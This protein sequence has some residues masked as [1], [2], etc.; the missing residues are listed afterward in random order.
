MSLLLNMLSRLVVTFLPRSKHPL[1]SWLQSPSAE[2]LVN[3]RRIGERHT[4][5]NSRQTDFC[6][7]AY[8]W[9][10]PRSASNPDLHLP[11]RSSPHDLCHVWDLPWWLLA[12]VVLFT[13]WEHIPACLVA[14]VCGAGSSRGIKL[15]HPT[16]SPDTQHRCSAKSTNSDVSNWKTLQVAGAYAAVLVHHWKHSQ[17]AKLAHAHGK[18]RESIPGT[19]EGRKGPCSRVVKG[20]WGHPLW[21]L[22]LGLQPV[23]CLGTSELSWSPPGIFLRRLLSA[24][25]PWCTI[26]TP[27]RTCS[28]SEI[29]EI[30][31]L[32][33]VLLLAGVYV[34]FPM[35]F[36]L[37]YST[38]ITWLGQFQQLTL[39]SVLAGGSARTCACTQ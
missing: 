19:W 24:R 27:L 23:L 33:S 36:M 7:R 21:L 30:S 3:I 5:V 37:C 20:L 18:A 25:H 29:T 35:T 6:F 12:N 28:F 16:Y 34:P 15:S 31:T 38:S 8:A 9:A 39:I 10:G 26:L 1:I 22:C 17:K 32:A 14:Q 13:M 2:P 4:I 11:V